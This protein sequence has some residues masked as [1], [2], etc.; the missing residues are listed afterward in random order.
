[1][2]A[3]VSAAVASRYINR[4]RRYCKVDGV[5]ALSREYNV[6]TQATYGAVRRFKASGN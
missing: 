1:M 6:S 4:S 2:D 5:V 3:L